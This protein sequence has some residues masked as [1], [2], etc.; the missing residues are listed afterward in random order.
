MKPNNLSLN[1]VKMVE[2]GDQSKKQGQKLQVSNSRGIFAIVTAL[3]VVSLFA[4][5]ALGIEVG[6]W[7]VV[8]AELS[9]SVDAAALLGAKNYSNPFLVTEDLMA[10]VGQAN[11]SPGLLGTEGSPLITGTKG[12]EG[13]VFVEGSTNVLNKV[14]QVVEMQSHI[15]E[16]TYDKTY[17][18]SSGVAQQREVEIMMVLD[19]SGSMS[20]AMGNLKTAAQSFVDFFEH[21][22]DT[23]QF[24]LITFASGVVVER[25]LGTNF[26][27][28]MTTAIGNMSASGGTNTE[29]ALDQADGPSGFTDQTGVPGDERVQ[30]FLVFFSDGNPTAFRADFTRNGTDYDAVGY[31]A[32]WDIKLMNPTSQFSYL[33][34]KQYSTGDG[35]TTSTTV[36]QS[37]QPLAGYSNTKWH[38]LDDI[39]YG[40]TGYSDFLGVN[41][42][43]VLGTT[44]AEKCSLN[45]SKGKDYVEAIT[46]QMAID[47]AQEIKDKGIKIYTIGLGGVDEAFLS[48]IA[49]GPGFEYFAP[50]S[51]DLKNLFQKIATN[52]RL[53]LVQ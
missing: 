15:A 17:I 39:T 14:T 24:G 43:D 33:N 29:D 41:Y 34:V 42:S 5:V 1:T 31:A 51:A 3:S 19:E 6:R 13:K 21:T 26:F 20:S 7:Y 27:D 32:D 9:K 4:F 35:K 37:G 36:C 40:V 25:A 18:T 10:A 8:R 2:P 47:H 45:K 22:E 12:A 38:I 46:K 28:D 30:Q 11:F 53:R 52:I 44:D 49:S 16:G 50:T 23:D 48:Q